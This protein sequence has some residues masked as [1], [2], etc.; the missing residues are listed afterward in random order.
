MAAVAAI[1]VGAYFVIGGGGGSSVANDGPHKLIAPNTV[2]D[3]YEKNPAQNE[4]SEEGG[5]EALRETVKNAKE[6]EASYQLK[7]KA[8]P[9]AGKTLSFGG[10]YGEIEDPEKAVDLAF[11]GIKAETEKN[12]GKPNA[13]RMEGEPREYTPEGLD[14][15][16]LKCQQAKMKTGE[17]TLPE[18]TVTMCA[19]ADHSTAAVVMP[20]DMA[21]L[22]TGAGSSADEAAATTAKL[23]KEIRVK[24]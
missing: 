11:A 4:S 13:P 18:V 12:A 6:V 10:L 7:N 24:L 16:V 3:G 14:G 2:L 8:N 9:L 20:I 22:L 21:S 15:A 23:R 5:L 19:W 17:K 1:A